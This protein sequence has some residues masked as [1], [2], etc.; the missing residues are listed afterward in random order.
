MPKAGKM[1]SSK[2]M[3][4]DPLANDILEQERTQGLRTT[5]RVK[6][7]RKDEDDEEAE[8]FVPSS[9]SKRV[10][11]VADEQKREADES[12]DDNDFMGSTAPSEAG[13]LD[14]DHVVVEEDDDVEDLAVDKE[15]YVGGNAVTADEERIMQQFLPDAGPRGRSLADMILDKIREK[16]ER[17]AQMQDGPGAQDGQGSSSGISPK[18]VQVY[19][20]IGKWMKRYKSGKMPKAFKIC[21]NLN[22]W[23]EVLYLTNPVDWSPAAMREAVKIF[24]S[25]LNPKMAQRFY[26]LVLL[27]AV[28]EDVANNKRLNFN[29]FESLKKSL[30]KPAAFFKGIL[31]PLA[32]ESCTL[33]E[34]VIVS[35]VLAKVSVPVLHASAAII[36]L[37]EMTPWYGTTS[38]F[39]SVLLNKKYSL[40]Y[41]VV[42]ALVDHYTSF[43]HDERALPLVWHRSL[44]IFA[45][46][47][48]YDL[49]DDQRK[50]LKELLRVQFHD[51]VGVEIRREIV[52]AAAAAGRSQAQQAASRKTSGDEGMDIG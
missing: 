30:F 5:P 50:R 46:R 27:P 4:H 47:Y 33:R 2:G 12:D 15:G 14:V 34:A 41:K 17:S 18:I 23:E 42:S 29:Y 22:N 43:V 35:S 44:L 8:R 45:Q 1:K 6:Q 25:S 21:P 37:C 49:T 10:L 3:R 48:K 32:Q 9:L 20:S 40:P 31:L 16:E 11:D 51:Q 26:N 52:G 7:R 38:I 13:D 36:R 19:G 39:I 24:A 28:R